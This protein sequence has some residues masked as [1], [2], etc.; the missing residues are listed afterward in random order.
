MCS[1]DFG[2]VMRELG[3][4]SVEEDIRGPESYC[5]NM[6]SLREGIRYVVNLPLKM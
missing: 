3:K 5:C 6:I 2:Q 1:T 4:D